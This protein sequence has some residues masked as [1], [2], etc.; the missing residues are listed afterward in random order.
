MLEAD[1]DLV[2]SGVVSKLLRSRLDALDV[3]TEQIARNH[4]ASDLISLYE[5]SLRSK[6]GTS[7][8]SMSLTNDYSHGIY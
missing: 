1:R 4:L 7:S 2:C 8:S 3:E 6:Y 5:E